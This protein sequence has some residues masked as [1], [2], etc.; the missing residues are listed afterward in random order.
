MI[1]DIVCSFVNMSGAGMSFSGP[2]S[3]TISVVN[4]R[5][6]ACSSRGDISRGL[7]QPPPL[8]PHRGGGGAPRVPKPVGQVRVQVEELR[9]LAELLLRFDQ[10]VVPFLGLSP[11][12]KWPRFLPLSPFFPS[13]KLVPRRRPRA[14]HRKLAA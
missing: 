2:I 4:R 10:H 5:V 1:Q 3:I 8:A 6:R 9:S 14:L 7:Q 11:A 12:R 13:D